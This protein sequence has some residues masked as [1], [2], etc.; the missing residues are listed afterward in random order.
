VGLSL[1]QV[2]VGVVIDIGLYFFLFDQCPIFFKLE[3]SF[4]CFVK[5]DYR[6]TS[7]SKNIKKELSKDLDLAQDSTQV[8]NF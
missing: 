6:L 1:L 7:L 3:E 8:F 5:E 2:L 4:Y